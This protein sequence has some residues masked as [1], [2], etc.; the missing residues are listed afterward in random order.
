MNKSP[1][2]KRFQDILHLSSTIF[3]QEETL[4]NEKYFRSGTVFMIV[5]WREI[6]KVTYL[7]LSKGSWQGLVSYDKISSIID[8]LGYPNDRR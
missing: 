7:V 6:D 8:K 5:G 4:I 1:L 3:L 2:I